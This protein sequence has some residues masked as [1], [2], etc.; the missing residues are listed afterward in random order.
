MCMS[1]CVDVEV[2]GQPCALFLRIL[3]MLSFNSASLAG[4]PVIPQDVCLSPPPKHRDYKCTP[5]YPAFWHGFCGSDSGPSWLQSKLFMDGA[6]YLANWV[7]F[8][9]QETELVAYSDS[10]R[11]LPKLG[12]AT[13]RFLNSKAHRKL[14]KSF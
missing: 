9:H 12:S 14:G 2:T 10:L 8:K 11:S 4:R 7:T 3:S 6:I 5:L 13:Q 1:V